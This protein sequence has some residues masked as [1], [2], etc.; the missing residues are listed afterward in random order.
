MRKIS[1]FIVSSW[2]ATAVAAL[3]C[4]GI[5]IYS[6][7]QDGTGGVL[8]YLNLLLYLI[9]G[10]LI[11]HHNGERQTYRSRRVTLPATLFFMGCAINPQLA[12][13]QEGTV[14]L[15]LIALAYHIISG[16]YRNQVAMGSYF[17][18]FCLIGTISL[19]SPQ[20]LFMTPALILCCSFMQSLH[21]RAILASLLG[22]L[23]PYWA[24]FCILFLT[25]KPHL[26][27]SFVDK[28][29]AV[30]SLPSTPLHIPIGE[31]ESLSVPMVA[32]QLCWTLLLILPAIAHHVLST[33]SAVRARANRYMQI[34]SMATLLVATHLLPSLYTALQPTVAALTAILGYGFFATEKKGRNTRPIILLII[35]LLLL[36]LYVWNNFLTY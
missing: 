8:S 32:L 4:M 10:A 23:T 34:S 21:L 19:Q 2:A 20:L 1:H 24:A 35:W 7:V 18:A 22:V 14:Y 3:L 36:G 16:T 31:G 26:I 29:T 12:S 9:F 5:W 25:E 30:T 6:I 13:W 27:S 15:V 28:L 33:T 17:A 11:G